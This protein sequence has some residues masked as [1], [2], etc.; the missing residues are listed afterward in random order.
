MFAQSAAGI[1]PP[2]APTIAAQSGWSTLYRLGALAALFTVAIIPVQLV[3]FTS[4]P[5]PQT[6]LGWF[7]LFQQNKLLG[8]LGF[9]IL[10][11]F[12][13]VLAVPTAIALYM[14]LRETDRSLMALFLAL[15]V[16]GSVLLIVARPAVDMLY[17]S[18]QYAAATSEAQRSLYLAAGETLRATFNGTGFHASYNLANVGYMLV[19]LVLFKSAHFGRAAAYAGF[20]AGLVGFGLY[21]PTIGIFVSVLSVLFLAVYQVLVARGLWRLAGSSGAA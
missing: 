20:L 7:E 18:D 3:V 11:V 1:K 6:A 12:N 14:A 15:S 4:S 2:A 5:P 19:A 10:F 8:L 21:L 17:L 16:V 13:A 9:E